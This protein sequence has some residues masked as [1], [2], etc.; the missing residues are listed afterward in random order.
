MNQNH[1]DRLVDC[2]NRAVK[3]DRPSIEGLIKGIELSSPSDE[4]AEFA[5]DCAEMAVKHS[6]L[7]TENVL[8]LLMAG[9]SIASP[10]RNE[11]MLNYAL[12][13]NDLC[14]HAVGMFIKQNSGPKK[15]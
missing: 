12:D 13:V 11:Y 10:M 7:A 1:R 9:Q 8:L 14:L 4:I 5:V 6:K 3:E 2:Y 15:E